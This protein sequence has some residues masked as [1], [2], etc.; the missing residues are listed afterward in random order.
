M[1]C[2]VVAHTNLFWVYLCCAV[3]CRDAGLGCDSI[4]AALAWCAI[5]TEVLIFS[6]RLQGEPGWGTKII[7][8]IKEFMWM[9]LKYFHGSALCCV[10]I[11]KATWVSSTVVLGWKD[12]ACGVTDFTRRN[13]GSFLK[14]SIRI[15]CAGI[16]FKQVQSYLQQVLYNIGERMG[17][18]LFPF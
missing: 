15:W 3:P 4:I 2:R 1:P 5:G 13:T 12:I 10:N 7:C 11:S 8:N 6:A 17:E 9:Y 16:F 18:H 14:K